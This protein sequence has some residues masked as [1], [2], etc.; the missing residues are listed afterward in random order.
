MKRYIRSTTSTNQDILNQYRS[1]YPELDITVDDNSIE[2]YNE[3]EDTT[4]SMDF[5][6]AFDQIPT[7]EFEKMLRQCIEIVL[8]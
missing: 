8:D 6:V 5:Y 7:K 2:V 3:A 4:S 1:R